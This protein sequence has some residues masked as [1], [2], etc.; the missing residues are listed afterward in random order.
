MS[1]GRSSGWAQASTRQY[2]T[3]AFLWEKGERLRDL[4]TLGGKQ[5]AVS[6]I[7]RGVGEVGWGTYYPAAINNRGQVVGASTL[8]DRPVARLSL[9]NGKITDLGTLGNDQASA[10]I[11]IDEHGQ[12]VGVSTSGATIRSLIGTGKDEE[13]AFV[14]AA[15]KI[16]R[17][18]TLGGSQSFASA[19]NDRGQIVGSSLTKNGQ[20][21]A[22][23]WTFQP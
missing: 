23:L 16:T 3:H 21:H 12:S 14:W 22:V 15:G 2:A 6:I 13:H 17:L 7:Y 4:G 11:A 1:A 8:R 9:E 19:I 20:R 5:S 18:P 10:A